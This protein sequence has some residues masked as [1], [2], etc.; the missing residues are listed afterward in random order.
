MLIVVISEHTRKLCYQKLAENKISRPEKVSPIKKCETAAG[1]TRISQ[2]ARTENNVVLNKG[3]LKDPNIP[4]S[5][6]RFSTG[7]MSLESCSESAILFSQQQMRDVQ[8]VANKL[9]REL[10]SLKDIV[11]E[12]LRP[13]VNPAAPLKY[14]TEEVC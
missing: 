4:R 9:S 7:C 11:E 2:K 13:N 3:I 14:S 6:P 10:K 8:S 1:S 5:V 12:T